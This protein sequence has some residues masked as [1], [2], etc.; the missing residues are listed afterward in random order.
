MFTCCC[1]QLILNDRKHPVTVAYTGVKGDAD[2]HVDIFES[3][4]QWSGGGVVK[5][6]GPSGQAKVPIEVRIAPNYQVRQARSVL[7]PTG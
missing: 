2:I 7:C 3:G 6:T 5:V 4:S 1:F